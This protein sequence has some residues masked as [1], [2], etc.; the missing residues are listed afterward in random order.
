[1]AENR[2]WHTWG[3]GNEHAKA[4]T[5]AA[6]PIVPGNAR[7]ALTPPSRTRRPASSM[8]SRHTVLRSTLPRG[9]RPC[10]VSSRT[11][12]E[13]F[14]CRCGLFAGP[15]CCGGGRGGGS[16]G[17]AAS[18]GP[19]AASVQPGQARPP[20]GPTSTAAAAAPPPPPPMPPPLL[21]GCLPKALPSPRAGRAAAASAP[22][23]SAALPP[24]PECS[25]VASALPARK[26]TRC[27]RL[28]RCPSRGEVGGAEAPKT[29]WKGRGAP[30]SS[31][32]HGAS[33]SWTG[34][35]VGGA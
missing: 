26:G 2:S 22:G 6:L 33:G 24:P 23:C 4:S 8:R 27:G 19:S 35:K 21:A 1:M 13:R 3:G 28:L 25:A 15:G 20:S 9:C 29:A 11:G 16:A 18:A 34:R 31:E 30:S 10:S 17:D 12:S 32:L 7:P 5:T 14:G